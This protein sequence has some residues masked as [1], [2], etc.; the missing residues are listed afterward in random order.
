MKILVTGSS[1]FIGRWTCSTLRAKGNVVVGLD[2]KPKN[3][4]QEWLPFYHV[5][6]VN[7][8][9][10]E[11]VVAEVEPDVIIHLAARTDLGPKK[12]IQAYSSNIDGVKNLLNCVAKITT[13]KRVIVTSSQLVCRVGYVPRSDTD[14][15]PDTLYGQSKVLTEKI[16]RKWTVEA[17]SG[18]LRAQLQSGGHT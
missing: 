10:L 17:S 6:I 14:Y 16:T 1:G 4:D 7:E 5:D 15:C 18:A 3:S 9:R 13:I 8:R 2:K 11:S 12:D